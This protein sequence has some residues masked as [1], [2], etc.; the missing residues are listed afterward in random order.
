MIAAPSAPAPVVDVD[1]LVELV[2]TL[3]VELIATFLVSSLLGFD[4][5]SAPSTIRFSWPSRRSIRP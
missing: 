3:L 5:R 4:E 1:E 2:A